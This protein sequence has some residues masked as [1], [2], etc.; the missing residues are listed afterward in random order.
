[1]AQTVG[2]KPVPAQKS[3]IFSVCL[4][5]PAALF[6]VLLSCSGKS[7]AFLEPRTPDGREVLPDYAVV[8]TPKMSTTELAHLK[9]TNPA[10]IGFARLGDRRG[11]RVLTCQSQA[12]HEL[13]PT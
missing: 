5:V 2:F 13:V 9:Q 3:D 6:P 7:G 8:W 4:R 12:M 1:M 11:F 10:I